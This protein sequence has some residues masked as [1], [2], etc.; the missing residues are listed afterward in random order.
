MRVDRSPRKNAVRKLHL[1]GLVHKLRLSGILSQFLRLPFES[2]T[3]LLLGS[4][5]PA[6]RILVSIGIGVLGQ[7]VA[8]RSGGWD[9]GAS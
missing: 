9:F 1:C 3:Y 4:Q 8:D 7:G 2:L 5:I 6:A